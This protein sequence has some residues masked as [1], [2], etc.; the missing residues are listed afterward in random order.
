MR[1]RKTGIGGGSAKVQ[2]ER[3]RINQLKNRLAVKPDTDKEEYC[4]LIEKII[5]PKSDTPVSIQ[6]QNA[7]LV[8]IAL[9]EQRNEIVRKKYNEIYRVKKGPAAWVKYNRIEKLHGLYC[10]GLERCDNIRNN[11]VFTLN[12]DVSPKNSKTASPPQKTTANTEAP[13]KIEEAREKIQIA[14]EKVAKAPADVPAEQKNQNPPAAANAITQLSDGSFTNLPVSERE[15]NLADI[16]T[17]PA[18]PEYLV[19]ADGQWYC[20][21]TETGKEVPVRQGRQRME[22]IDQDEAAPGSYSPQFA[23]SEAAEKVT[24][25]IFDPEGNKGNGEYVTLEEMTQRKAERR[26]LAE[27][28]R[29]QEKLAQQKRKEAQWAAAYNKDR[30]IYDRWTAYFDAL[31]RGG[32]CAEYNGYRDSGKKSDKF[33]LAENKMRVITTQP[34]G[35]ITVTDYDVSGKIL[36]R[37]KY[38]NTNGKISKQIIC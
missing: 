9:E 32:V 21:D 11:R 19:D 24:S 5:K 22:E 12:V 23:T 37:A 18:D 10:A 3:T 30:A 4:K 8:R 25:K 6:D 7:R 36:T 28:E 27:K 16:V 1:A 26:A 35:N 38:V 34:N 31:Q 33:M 17:Q 15:H 14:S 20:V 13:A 29:A 2:E